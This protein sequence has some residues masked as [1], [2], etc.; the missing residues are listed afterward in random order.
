[1][2]GETVYSL[3][4]WFGGWSRIAIALVVLAAIGAGIM[5][6]QWRHPPA[7]P[8]ATRVEATLNVDVRQTT[9]WAPGTAEEMKA[10]YRRELPVRGWD[11]CGTQ[12]T[13]D[14]TNLTK[15]INRS[16]DA[17]DVYRRPGDTTFQGPTLEV[18]PVR[19]ENGMTFVTIFETRGG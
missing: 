18:W 19:T 8:G 3:V 4:R 13:P 9:F 15:L 17:I 14:C 10:F 5:W 1:M 6:E 11:Y 7:P 2:L 16:E 12:A